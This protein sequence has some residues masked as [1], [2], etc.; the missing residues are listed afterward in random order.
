MNERAAENYQR[1]ERALAHV[2][3]IKEKDMTMKAIALPIVLPEAKL[4]FWCW[5]RQLAVIVWAAA[6][7]NAI[8]Y[9]C[10]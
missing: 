6:L 8:L 1:F 2:K 10:R 4:C 5:Q 7:T 3:R 9:L